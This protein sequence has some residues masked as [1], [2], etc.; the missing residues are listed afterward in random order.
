MYKREAV[1]NMNMVIRA[2]KDFIQRI[3]DKN[4]GKRVDIIGGIGY[5]VSSLVSL[6][7]LFGSLQIF[8]YPILKQKHSAIFYSFFM[9]LP[10]ITFFITMAGKYFK[11][12]SR[13]VQ[14]FFIVIM[15]TTLFTFSYLVQIANGAFVSMLKGIKNIDVIP[16]SLLEGNIRIISFFVPLAI[17]IPISL[18]TFKMI[19]DKEIRKD[20][21]EYDV[22]ILLPNVNVM[23]DTTIDIKICEDLETGEDCI[24]PEKLAYEHF[25][26]QGG[27]GSGKTATY[28]RPYLAQLFYMKAYL[29]E[30]Q[31]KLA[32]EALKEGIAYMV[33]PVTNRYFNKSFTMDLIK[34]VTGKEEEFKA[35]FK[36]FIIGVRDK[37][38]LL[39]NEVIEDGN[40]TFKKVKADSVCIIKITIYDYGMDLAEKEFKFKANELPSSLV[41]AEE[42]KPIT[43]IE[44]VTQALGQ[45][46][47]DE[48]GEIINSNSLDDVEDTLTLNFP[49]I[50]EGI[51][52][53]IEVKEKGAGEIIFKSL[54]VSV[55]APDGG[56]PKDT[57]KIA[58]EYGVKVHK[59]DPFMEEIKKG[60]IGRYNPMLG[61]SPEKT[62]DI[63][64]SILVSMDQTNG[65]DG[66]PYFTNASVRAIRN[67]VILLKVMY[68]R[69]RGINPTLQ[70]ILDILNNFN[71]VVPLVDEMKKDEKLRER[72]SSVISYL[73]ASFY[74]PDLDDKG[75]IIPGATIGAQR[76]KTEE[77]IG[78]IINQLDNFLGREEIKY[79]LC[80]RE[81]SLD[82]AKV[83]E[84]GECIAIATRQNDLGERLGKAFALFFI[85]SM[86]NAVLSRYSEDEN[87][88]IP[89]YLVIDEFPFYINDAT[90]VFFTFAR[91]YRCSVTVAIQNMAQLREVSD[92]FRETIFTN[93]STKI[94]L[95]KS[96]VEDREYWSKFF[97]IEEQFE[98]ET[99]ISRGSLMSEKPS[100]SESVKGKVNEKA[101][102][103]E[104][105]INDM[106]FK[107]AFYTYTDS[108]GRQ[109]VG[110]GETDFLKIEEANRVESVDL[111]FASF[112]KESVEEYAKRQQSK[113]LAERRKIEA[114][115]QRN[116]NTTGDDGGINNDVSG[117]D[118]IINEVPSEFEEVN[119]TFDD[120]SL[121]LSD[122]I[123]SF[124][125]EENIN[126]N[127]DP[128]R[129]NREALSLE[130]R[131]ENYQ[132]H[133]NMNIKNDS[134]S[135]DDIEFED[136]EEEI[137]SELVEE[138]I[139]ESNQMIE[140]SRAAKEEKPLDEL[141]TLDDENITFNDGLF[142]EKLSIGSEKIELDEETPVI[143][144]SDLKIEEKI[145][146]DSV[147]VRN[148]TVPKQVNKEVEEFEFELDFDITGVSKKNKK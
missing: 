28:I 106:R 11:K 49:L 117:F 21:I 124:E 25:F 56:L 132:V 59:I 123:P 1:W 54:G 35:K 19:M 44:N 89:H 26:L 7:V 75:K 12:P 78:G 39:Y 2:A 45:E 139:M 146:L 118:P 97:G 53:K 66:N 130:D 131:N 135:L 114:E 60:G 48:Y 62:G 85:L 107:N 138:A 148:T 52:Y 103:T 86:Q 67:I 134:I 100:Y 105:D 58:R 61:D 136:I 141:I 104:Q 27:T 9:A 79:I 81:D 128:L 96:N 99:G 126:S 133:G 47:K 30:E 29:S 37:E 142:D 17:V 4:N 82:L 116:S 83:L 32:H 90:K 110:K 94:L 88:E 34:P 115:R 109:R 111:D 71:L 121:N 140:V 36:R 73:E 98:L 92:I 18:L 68:P 108:K 41:V 120:S 93:T 87:P 76:K 72:W 125:V 147:E 43:I 33:A 14:Q 129:S 15:T 77:A 3:V 63:I 38:V 113:K 70:D 64:S 95:P 8:R 22:D 57:I 5:G 31:K 145:E 127:A 46:V 65:Q 10:M 143:I 102:I 84:K 137:A 69:M 55:V 80:D 42:Y 50:K 112:N 74:P 122:I 20:L 144:P 16:Y 101:R 51:T 91:K 13:R 6:Y 24:V 40:V 23:D 119:N